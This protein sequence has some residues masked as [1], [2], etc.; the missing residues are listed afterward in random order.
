MQSVDVF[1]QK[2]QKYVPFFPGETGHRLFYYRDSLVIFPVHH[3]T[4]SSS[5][6]KSLAGTD[7][8]L[9][10]LFIDLR[11]LSF[12]EYPALSAQS[13]FTAKYMQADSTPIKYGWNFYSFAETR[14]FDS[15]HWIT[16]TTISNLRYRRLQ[17]SYTEDYRNSDYTIQKRLHIVHLLTS[18]AQ[19]GSIFHMSRSLEKRS[20][21]G[22]PFEISLDQCVSPRFTLKVEVKYVRPL[23]KEENRV[24]DA[25]EKNA[26]LNPVK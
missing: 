13:K 8:I 24:F 15:V 23:T 16:D 25:W 7:E 10:V 9:Y 21:A 3:F 4:F 11:T 2:T 17:S 20:K 1:N 5:D 18:C 22:C 14:A 19:Q 26:R 12:Y 6:P